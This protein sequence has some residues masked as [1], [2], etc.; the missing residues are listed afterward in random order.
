MGEP[1]PDSERE[2]CLSCGLCCN[3]GL[4]SHVTLTDEDREVLAARRLPVP[5]RIEHPCTFWDRCCTVYSYRPQA[6]RKYRCELLTKL[7]SGDVALSDAL[8]QVRTALELRAR[9]IDILP[10]TGTVSRVAEEWKDRSGRNSTAH[11]KAMLDYVVYRMFV[12]R[13]FLA[14][15]QRWVT[16]APAPAA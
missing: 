3:S 6:C 2:L 14:P 15:K 8:G 13:H 11:L 10:D 4:F 7:H 1:V 16:N 12:E 9:F 5:E